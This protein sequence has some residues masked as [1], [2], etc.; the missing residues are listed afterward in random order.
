[1]LFPLLSFALLSIISLE[2]QSN[3]LSIRRFFLIT[4][5]FM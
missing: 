1:M 4:K 2:Q 3:Q 5:N